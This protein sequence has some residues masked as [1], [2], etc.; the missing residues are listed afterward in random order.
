MR[1]LFLASLIFLLLA[2]DA[3]A[4]TQQPNKGIPRIGYLHTIDRIGKYD[5][6]FLKGLNDL[7]YVEGKT[8]AIEHRF[9]K[10]KES[11][12]LRKLASEFVRL[13]V[14]VIVALVPAAVRAAKDATQTIP[15]VM[16]YSRDPVADGL[17]ASLAK[18]GGN[19]TGVTSIAE[20]LSTKRIELIKEFIPGLTRLG[21][22][23]N[24][25]SR[26]NQKF[27]ADAAATSH[28]LG[29]KIRS[30]P[31]RKA[32]DIVPAFRAAADEGLQGFVTLRN[33]EIVRNRRRIAALAIQYRLPAVFDEREFATAGGLMSYGAN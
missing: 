27:F 15:I 18:P 28:L 2:L 26:R 29:V 31:V 1:I 20:A 4:Q 30:L 16:R 14:D 8:I 13:K 21:I 25:E 9:A 32:G 3:V 12:R 6:A 5:R 22:M 19:I 7:G 33:P 23:W 10:M 24:S 11:S 17:V